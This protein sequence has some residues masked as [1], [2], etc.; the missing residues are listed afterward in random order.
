M[1]PLLHLPN[2]KWLFGKALPAEQRAALSTPLASFLT[3]ET[4]LRLYNVR[5]R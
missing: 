2:M 3:I 4:W 5:I 1:R